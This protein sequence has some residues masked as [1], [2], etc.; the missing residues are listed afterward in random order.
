MCPSPASRPWWWRRQYQHRRVGLLA[1][2]ARHPPRLDH[3]RFGPDP[4]SR[5]DRREDI[6]R[7]AARCEGHI[8][9]VPPT[10]VRVLVATKPV[11]FRNGMDGLAAHVQ[12]ELKADPFSGII[13]VFRAK[14]S[15]RI[16]S[17]SGIRPA[18]VCSAS[19]W[20]ER[21]SADQLLPMASCACRQHSFQQGPPEP[22]LPT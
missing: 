6:D 10:S 14:R 12:E 5:G 11:D 15:D 21:S 7:C 2:T 18:C 19:G 17:C 4:G 3:C 22:R 20:K 16:N 1:R 9:I 13:Y 8:M